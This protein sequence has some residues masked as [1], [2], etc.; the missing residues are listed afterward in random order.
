MIKKLLLAALLFIAPIIIAADQYGHR[1]IWDKNYTYTVDADSGHTYNRT[2][3]ITLNKVIA[4]FPMKDF[5]KMWVQINCSS[6]PTTDEDTLAF[7]FK[8]PNGTVLAADSIIGVTSTA[9]L[10]Y[11]RADTTTVRY[12]PEVILTMNHYIDSAFVS[13]HT[14]DYKISIEYIWKP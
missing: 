6:A 2:D 8:T 4:T 9:K 14:Y 13:E 3:P 10:F 7:Y 1:V 11:I 5:G 12:I